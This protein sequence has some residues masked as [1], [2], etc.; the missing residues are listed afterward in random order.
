MCFVFKVKALKSIL[1]FF[2]F[3]AAV[4]SSEVVGAQVEPCRVSYALTNSYDYKALKSLKLKDI[5]IGELSSKS[6]GFDV[7]KLVV[8]L[9]C[10]N[11][12]NLPT[13]L[14]VIVKY[15]VLDH[16]WVYEVLESGHFNLVNKLGD[17]DKSKSTTYADDSLLPIFSI[18]LDSGRYR[19]FFL[20]IGTSGSLQAPL[21]VSPSLETRSILEPI[22]FLGGVYY[23][24]VFAMIVFNLFLFVSLR[25][26]L[27]LKYVLY[28]FFYFI[29]QAG[30]DGF[31][32][33]YFWSRNEWMTRY[34]VPVSIP[35]FLGFI[36]SFCRHYL[37]LDAL[38]PRLDRAFAFFGFCLFVFG[39]VGLF[40]PYRFAAG[41]G[42]IGSPLVALF[43]LYSSAIA[44]RKGFRPANFFFLAWFV[45]LLGIVMMSMRNLG[46]A[47]HTFIT[48]YAIQ[49]GSGMET[50]LIAF[51][52]AYR[53]KILRQDKERSDLDNQKLKVEQQVYREAAKLASQ[54]AHDIRSPLSA[55]QIG[56]SDLSAL[57]DAKRVLV[58]SA[59]LRMRDIAN[60]LL[61]QYKNAISDTIG[62]TTV[63]FDKL[64]SHVNKTDPV[65]LAA[66]VDS[67][68]AEKR[69]QF[70][71]SNMVHVESIID[72]ESFALFSKVDSLGFKRVLSNLINNSI[73]AAEGNKQIQIR[74]IFRLSGSA[75]E[76]IVEDNGRGMSQQ[77]LVDFNKGIFRS[78]GKEHAPQAG[79]GI[80]LSSAF[81][82]IKKMGGNLE[83]E[84]KLGEHT[85]V[86]MKF[87]CVGTPDWFAKDIN[88]LDCSVIYIVDDD[89]SI[90]QAWLNKFSETGLA[91]GLINVEYFSDL[92]SFCN[93]VVPILDRSKFLVLIDCEFVGSNQTGLDII[94]KLKLE[95]NSVLVTSRYDDPAIVHDVKRSGV[96]LL[97]K[98]LLSYV[99]IYS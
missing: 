58:R 27:Y 69:Y 91:L 92:N 98:N 30:A 90:Y 57:P 54:V 7:R 36:L 12:T 78:A 1:T 47:P 35:L 40:L 5:S 11:Y 13:S 18:T 62:S 73:E 55:I 42:A 84:S 88:I 63:D 31:G 66:I 15:A 99:K 3:S 22:N 26:S 53:I 19:D 10:T 52:L 77:M 21:T 87:P 44:I 32:N 76:I 25:D 85:K 96:R 14:D 59:I 20:V 8:R 17:L 56:L 16:V 46:L 24:I 49:I 74:V 39:I 4:N 50:M 72:P 64:Q 65:M 38:A 75:V 28:V 29:F 23:G 60:N 6:F 83:F 45:F 79:S 9:Q 71:G 82:F 43:C 95:K 61:Q 93:H 94:K 41:M 67:L 33:F 89:E 2:V 68:V 86:I 48:T 70:R 51:G 34:V 81:S 97:P 80:G 37:N